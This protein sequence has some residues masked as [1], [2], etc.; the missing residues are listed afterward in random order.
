MELHPNT[1]FPES[2]PCYHTAAV[3][4]MLSEIIEHVRDDQ[5][6]FQEPKA[7]AL[8]ATSADVLMGLYNAF[9]RYEQSDNVELREPDNREAPRNM[10]E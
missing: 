9:D 1:A 2:H 10:N 5:G 8:F 6:K 7:Q 3:K 4:T